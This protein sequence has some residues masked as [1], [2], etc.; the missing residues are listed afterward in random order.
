MTETGAAAEWPEMQ[1]APSR[2]PTAYRSSVCSQ[3][4]S[5][6]QQSSDVVARDRGQKGHLPPPSKFLSMGKFSENLLLLGKLF[7]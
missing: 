7:R 6:K 5:A 1:L 3:I 2:D 4:Y